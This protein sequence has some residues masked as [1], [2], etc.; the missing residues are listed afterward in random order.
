MS[1]GLPTEMTIRNF[2]TKALEQRSV[3]VQTEWSYDTPIG[4]LVPDML[5]RNGAEYV[6]ETKLGAESKLLDAIV[7]LYDYSKYTEAKGA[8]AV[9][10][11]EELRRRWSPEIL[12]KIAVDPKLKYIVT[13]IFKDFRPSQ[14]FVGNL[15]EVAEWIASQVLKP[16]VLEADTGFAIKVLTE[17]VDTMALSLRSLKTQD[18]EEI[19]GGKTVFENILQ[20]EE[21]HY[22]LDEMKQAA[23]Y[24]LANQIIF[25]HVLS[26]TDSA[27]FKEIDETKIN[28]PID[29][30]KYFEEVLKK[31]YTSVFGFDVASKL[32]ESATNVIKKVIVAVKALAPEKIG[33]DVLGKVFHDL[34]PF[35]IRKA[36]AAFYT[37]NEAAEILANLSIDKPDAEVMDL[38]CGSGTLLVAAYRRKREL[39]QSTGTQLSLENHKRFLEHDLTGIDIMPFAAHLAVMHLSLQS[40]VHEAEKVRVAVWDSTELKPNMNIPAISS[41]L[42][43]AYRKPTLDMFGKG[44]IA[45]REDAYIKKGAITLEGVGGSEIPLEKADVVIMN[46]PFT[47]AERLPEEYK[48]QLKVRFKE[49]KG[50]VFGRVGLHIF[51]I[52]LADRFVKKGG[53]VAWVLP[54][55]VLRI[56]S[57]EGIRKLWTN[58]YHVEYII[59]TDER[60]AFSEAAQFRE[61]LLIAKKLKDYEEKG[62]APSDL[63]CSVATLKRLPRELLEARTIAEKLRS[64]HLGKIGDTFEDKNM[65]IFNVSQGDLKERS[66][67]LFTLIAVS[68]PKLV[69]LW[70]RIENNERNRMIQ[71][72]KY[73]RTKQ[74]E[75]YEDVYIPPFNSTFIIHEQRAIKKNDL[76][77]IKEEK[78]KVIIAENRFTRSNLEAPIRALRRGLRRPSGCKIM[79]I[80]DSLDY[81]VVDRFKDAEQ[82]FPSKKQAEKALQSISRWRKIVTFKESN[83]VVSRRFDL[84]ARGTS[85]LAFYSKIPIFGIDMWSVKGY[86]DEDAKIFSLWFN[87]TLNIL[88][89]VIYRTETRG[90]WMKLHE[91]QIRNSLML[92]PKELTKKERT[93]LLN[94]FDKIATREFPSIVAQLRDR[95]NLRVQIDK[96]ILKILGYNDE[97]TESILSQLYADL[98]IEIEKL[99]TLMAG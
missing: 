74:I 23:T 17:A 90:A 43:A 89:M 36:V 61:V 15:F 86:N 44:K 63:I 60:A 81:V 1:S 32:P 45:T 57:M 77:V 12:E 99:K 33:H 50:L 39:L 64:K 94:L 83:V 56:L 10:F 42:R 47:R 76:W 48:G 54:A 62:R 91:Y 80:S 69:T 58:N 46:P 26:R 38:A 37:N 78:P 49:Y 66:N 68:N 11:P 27:N 29:L 93:E 85:L 18:I 51:F 35:N 31:D 98:T 7:Q 9:L 3:K 95:S 41:E 6:V 88:Q 65:S 70:T 4:R 24:L 13:A 25:Y 87:S 28:K 67:N 14:R 84:S 72:D 21:G 75:A 52:L 8:F 5:L 96:M 30:L 2:L 73:F 59:T 22:P 55:T 79:N 92:N 97:E 20:Y 71:C 53:R 19:F 16:L 82:I 40:L 34:I